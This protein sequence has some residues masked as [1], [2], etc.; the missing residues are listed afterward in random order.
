MATCAEADD[1]PD[2]KEVVVAID[3]GTTYSGYALAYQKDYTHDRHTLHINGCDFKSGY[4]LKAPTC[5]L[6]NT[7]GQFHSFGFD[8]ENMYAELTS[9][10]EHTGWY[11][12]R[13]FKMMLYNNP[14]ISHHSTL[15]DYTGKTMNA[16]TVFSAI[17]LHLRQE[18]VRKM[19]ERS[20]GA[21]IQD[22]KIH[23]VLTVPAIWSD[24]AKQFMRESAKRAG[25]RSEQLDIALE[26]EAASIYCKHMSVNRREQQ[27]D[28]V[29]LETIRPGTKYMVLDA[30]AGPRRRFTPSGLHGERGR[31]GRDKGGQGV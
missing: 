20:V 15:Q 14:S 28:G 23:W 22:D 8:A 27:D 1:T 6:F 11:Y 12:F 30:G 24:Q 9:T 21:G 18:T 5:I 16:I 25:I 26:P 7:Q 3:F 19:R 2:N 17:I 29:G 10:D 4:S 31:L 13:R